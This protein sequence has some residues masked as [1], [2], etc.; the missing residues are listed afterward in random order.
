MQ[1]MRMSGG[2]SNSNK[3]VE[4]V[5]N[6]FKIFCSMSIRITEIDVQILGNIIQSSLQRRI[7]MF[8]YRLN[9]VQKF[10]HVHY[11]A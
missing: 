7:H 8:S 1:T 5:S 3:H 2:S 11:E 4:N 9:I 10:E 6:Y